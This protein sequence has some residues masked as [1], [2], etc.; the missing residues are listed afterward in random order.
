MAKYSQAN[1]VPKI[2]NNAIKVTKLKKDIENSATKLST[3]NPM[4]EKVDSSPSQTRDWLLE[5]LDLSGMKAKWPP[6][7]QAKAKALLLSYSDIFSKDEMDLG[8]N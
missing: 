2:L 7:L 1:Q 8:K 6:D 4:K 5:K 3:T